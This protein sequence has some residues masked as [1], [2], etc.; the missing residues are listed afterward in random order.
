MTPKAS[1]TQVGGDHYKNLAVEPWTAMESWLTREEFI[2][3]LKG[4][5]V[6]YTARANTSKGTPQENMRKAHHYSLKLQEVLNESVDTTT[7]P[8]INSV[9]S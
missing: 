9:K 1:L 6:K 3:F 4:N 2:G 8:T 5:I 7:L